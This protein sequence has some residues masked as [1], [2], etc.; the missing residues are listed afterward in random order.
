M[1]CN[2]WTASL[3]YNALI[4]HTRLSIHREK[5]TLEKMNQA[6]RTEIQDLA[7]QVMQNA[8]L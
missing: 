2:G 5:I 7:K 4:V 6:L 1:P 8:Q 3:R